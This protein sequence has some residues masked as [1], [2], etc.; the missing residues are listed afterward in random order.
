MSGWVSMVCQTGVAL[1]TDGGVWSRHDNTLVDIRRK[2]FTSDLVP[3]AITSQGRFDRN[4]EIS[5]EL[6]DRAVEM[7]VA[8]FI[9]GLQ[10]IADEIRDR[11][12]E[13]RG[14]ETTRLCV[15]ACHPKLGGVHR[16]FISHDRQ[17]YAATGEKTQHAAYAVVDPGGGLFFSGG[18]IRWPD[19]EAAQLMPLAGEDMF[20][21]AVRAG[22]GLMNL[23]RTKKGLDVE[24]G[25]IV[26]P[27]GGQVDLTLM[28]EECRRTD[29]I[30]VWPEDQ[31]GQR[32]NPQPMAK[33]VAGL[34]RAARRRR[35]RK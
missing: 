18:R 30:Y 12:G 9:D 10:D 16:T 24:T 20:A 23:I 33:P 27:V 11:Y 13:A 22:A 5:R 15:T 31:I 1:L 4:E 21:Y 34:N 14:Y 17:Y 35:A 19:I 25:E 26:Y 2:V 3:V 7:G 8:D 29:T 32:I 6:L 28:T